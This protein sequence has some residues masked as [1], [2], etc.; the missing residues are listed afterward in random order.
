[1]SGVRLI[2][3]AQRRGL[4]EGPPFDELRTGSIR[5]IDGG[6]R[7]LRVG[8]CHVDGGSQPPPDKAGTSGASVRLIG[9]AEPPGKPGGD[10]TS[11]RM[12]PGFPGRLQRGLG[13][14]S[15]MQNLLVLI[16][17]AQVQLRAI[18]R[19]SAMA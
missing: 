10:S 2:A 11:P 3:A 13:G 18:L 14:A 9:K 6:E 7:F 15:P 16:L 4:D 5:M 19:A 1:M 17:C 8:V 12:W